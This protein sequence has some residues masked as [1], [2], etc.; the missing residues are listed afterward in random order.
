[1]PFSYCRLFGRKFFLH[2]IK[3]LY[4]SFY[5]SFREKYYP[6]AAYTKYAAKY[7]PEGSLLEFNEKFV[8]VGENLI[9]C[10]PVNLATGVISKNYS[11]NLFCWTAPADS[12]IETFFRSS[13]MNY[14][15]TILDNK[16]YIIKNDPVNIYEFIQF[17]ID[18]QEVKRF[19]NKI[20][21]NLGDLI[22]TSKPAHDDKVFLIDR[23][24]NVVECFNVKD[25][26]WTPFGLLANICTSTG[27]QR[28]S[29]MLLTFTSA[30]LPINIILSCTCD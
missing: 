17:N 28:K 1:M 7:T 12:R 6:F 21:S 14:L 13:D 2:F 27:D 11:I 3:F 23:S 9:S 5:N 29:N 4:F 10:T 26:E 15:T 20:R 24:N 8:L 18:S 16:I 19:A 30:F 25:E 22:L